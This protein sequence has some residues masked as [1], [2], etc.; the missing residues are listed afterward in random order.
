MKIE[1]VLEEYNLQTKEFKAYWDGLEEEGAP[2]ALLGRRR[3]EEQ[4][5]LESFIREQGLAFIEA[6]LEPLREQYLSTALTASDPKDIYES[7]GAYMV[8]DDIVNYLLNLCADQ[9]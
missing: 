8:F 5:R 4:R 2:Q 6:I 7:R 9:E 3:A 1:Q